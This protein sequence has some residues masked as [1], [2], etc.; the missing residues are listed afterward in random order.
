MV[1]SSMTTLDQT[2]RERAEKVRNQGTNIVLFGGLG[3]IFLWLTVLLTGVPIDYLGGRNV[4]I[5]YAAA[6]CLPTATVL[7]FSIWKTSKMKALADEKN[8]N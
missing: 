1:I 5:I 6:V 7:V 2:A 8:L 4:S 3:A